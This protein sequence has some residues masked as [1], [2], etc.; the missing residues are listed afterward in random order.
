MILRILVVLLVFFVI[1][2]PLYRLMN[3]YVGK[4]SDEVKSPQ[5]RMRDLQDSID[6][7]NA[8]IDRKK[9]ESEK[10]VAELDEIKR[11]LNKGE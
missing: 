11:T 7:L 10:M 4:V 9:A 1:W 5:A 2:V 6:R 8:D 3:W